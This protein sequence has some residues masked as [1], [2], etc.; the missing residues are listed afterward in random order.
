MAMQETWLLGLGWDDE[1]PSDLKK[2]CQEWFSHYQNFPESEF[3]GAIVPLKKNVAD[4]SIHTMVDASLLAY[5]TVSYVRHKYEDGEAT[6]R[7]IAAKAK[8]A[9]T[10][11]ISV[12]RLELMAAVLGLRLARKVS[13]LLETPFENCTL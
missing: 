13:E 8:V 1:F 6:V 7:F 3:Q 12:P 5:A 4:T 11:A 10:K 2:T 9:P